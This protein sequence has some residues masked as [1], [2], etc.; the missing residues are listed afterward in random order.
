[1]IRPSALQ[2]AEKCG[3]A[4]VLAQEHPEQSAVATRGTEVHDDIAAALEGEPIT[5]PDVAAAV[6]YIRDEYEGANVKAEEALALL[7]PETDEVITRGRADVLCTEGD[8]VTVIDWKTGSPDNVADVDDN[9]QLAAYALAA[10]LSRNAQKIRWELVFLRGG[11][12]R[13]MSSKIYEHD[14]WGRWLD[15][16]TAIQGQRAVPTPGAHCTGC[17]Q[18]HYC[19]AWKA[20][21]ETALTLVGKKDIRITDKTATE[22][23][24]KVAAVR[25]AADMAEQMARAHVLA[26]G[27]VEADGKVWGPVQMPGRRSG[28]SV[29]DLEALDMAHLIKQGPGY[30]RWTWKKAKA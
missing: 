30:E 19:P 24:L 26:G 12:V 15:R 20:R 8:T 6:K 17:Y 21:A 7:D 28:P 25:E 2:I 23:L 22:L 14:Q 13:V 11:S 27:I 5:D 4:P 1:M 18:R 9:L 10:G 29:K 3:M 16:I